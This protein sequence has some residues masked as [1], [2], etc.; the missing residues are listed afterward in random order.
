MKI[1]FIGTGVMGNSIGGHLLDGGHEL[2]VY[3]RTASKAEDLLSKGAVWKNN[4]QELAQSAE[5]IFT[6]VGYPSDV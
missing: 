4:P 5:V 3:T 2:S 6:M 1:G